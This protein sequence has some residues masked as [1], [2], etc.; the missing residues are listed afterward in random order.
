MQLHVPDPDYT[1]SPRA[2]RSFWL[3]VRLVVGLLIVIWAVFGFERLMAIDLTQFGLR[4]RELAGLLGLATTPLLHGNFS[5]LMSN[6]LPLFV[7]GVAMLF[8]YPVAA[9]RAF[10]LIYVGSSGLAWLFARSSLHIGAS[11]LIYGI[12]AFVFVSGLIRRD[13]RSVGV[14]LMIWLLYGSMIW[15]VLPTGSGTSWELHLSG[16]AVGLVLAFLLERHDRPPL[17]RYDW[18]D[19]SEFEEGE[20]EQPWRDWH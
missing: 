10:P 8:L 7:G 2:I 14:S 11:G 13:L 12:L 20:D 9:L 3:A 18:E 1:G 4:P 15:G 17:K 6:T 19:E 16:A 5:H